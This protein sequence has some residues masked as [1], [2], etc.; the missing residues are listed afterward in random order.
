METMAPMTAKFQD[1]LSRQESL[2]ENN[3]TEQPNT[4]LPLNET[5]IEIWNELHEQEESHKQQL[6]GIPP[7]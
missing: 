4:Q 6:T 7:L 5:M 2:S 1:Q 3:S